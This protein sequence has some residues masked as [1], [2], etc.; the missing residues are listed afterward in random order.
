MPDYFDHIIINHEEKFTRYLNRARQSAAEDRKYSSEITQQKLRDLCE[1]NCG[2]K[3]KDWQI[4]ISE[5]LTLKLDTVLIAGT[6]S[7]KTTPFVLPLML[8]RQ[9]G[10][11]LMLLLISPLKA[12]QKDQA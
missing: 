3:A 10:Q 6:G 7:G 8:E 9:S 12:L 2:Y 11:Q 4:D 1:K 5:A